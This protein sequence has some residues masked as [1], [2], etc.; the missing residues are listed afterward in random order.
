MA[1]A[2]CRFC[3]HRC[4]VYRHVLDESN[5]LVFAGHLATCP[6]GKAFD[7]AKLGADADTA[8]NPIG[9]QP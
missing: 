7:R 1:G 5:R 8:W 6:E 2:Y 9:G 4:F 3:D